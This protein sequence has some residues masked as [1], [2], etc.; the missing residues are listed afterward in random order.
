MHVPT[1]TGLCIYDS[2]KYAIEGISLLMPSFILSDRFI[3]PIGRTP[4][5][6]DDVLKG[7]SAE[8]VVGKRIAEPHI[9]RISAPDHH[10]GLCNSKCGGVVF[11]SEAG[12]S[13]VS[14][15]SMNAFL[16]AGQHL[17]SSHCH[18]VDS[19]IVDFCYI[20]VRKQQI[21]HQIDDV[22]AGEVRS[23]VIAEA[24]GESPYKVLKDVAAVNCAYLIGASIV[25]IILQMDVA[26]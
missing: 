1:L 7:V 6:R 23:G 15:Q 16:H 13:S 25:F 18:I 26:E 12:Y 8:L 5:N 4:D 20:S 24:L 21:G 3:I 19:G 17:R 2:G 10:I 22:A 11:L 9:V 14:V